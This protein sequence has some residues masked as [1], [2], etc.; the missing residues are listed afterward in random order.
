MPLVSTNIQVMPNFR[1]LLSLT[2]FNQSP[3]CRYSILLS[4]TTLELKTASSV[5]DRICLPP[6]PPTKD[7]HCEYYHLT[8]QM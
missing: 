8:W 3:T 4:I 2:C 6:V 5:L 7:T 1:A